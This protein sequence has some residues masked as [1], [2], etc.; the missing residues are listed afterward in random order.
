MTPVETATHS[1]EETQNL[2]QHLGSR[3]RGGEVVELAADIGGGKTEFVRGLARGIGSNEQ[4]MSPTFTLARIYH[5]SACELH[6]FD[7]YR[8]QEAGIMQA[9][10]AESLDNPGVTVAVEWSQVVAEVLPQERL[11][12]RLTA[13]GDTERR[14]EFSASDERHQ[15]L[16]EGLV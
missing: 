12:I 1:P 13:A 10:L 3:L 5:G 11:T 14:L 16:I 6:H 7:F 4:V 9:E 2:G 8:L 15:Q